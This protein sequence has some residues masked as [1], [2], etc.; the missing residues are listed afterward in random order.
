VEKGQNYLI[1]VRMIT[2]EQMQLLR[3][4]W[5]AV[6]KGLEPSAELPFR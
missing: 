5:N 3:A 2:D 4:F 1:E 6:A